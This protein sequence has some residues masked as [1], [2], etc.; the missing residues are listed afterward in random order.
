MSAVRMKAGCDDLPGLFFLH[1]NGH[2]ALNL[3]GLGA[4]PPVQLALVYLKVLFSFCQSVAIQING[5][6]DH[7]E[8]K[9]IFGLCLS[10]SGFI[11][12]TDW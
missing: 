12:F 8:F 1:P 9:A 11:P 7:A 6:E 3:G 2:N 10:I 4:E 5:S